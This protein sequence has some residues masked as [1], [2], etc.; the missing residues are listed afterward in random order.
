MCGGHQTLLQS[1]INYN[2]AT[3]AT[4]QEIKI[5]Y[6]AAQEYFFNGIQTS[7]L[8]KNTRWTNRK[9]TMLQG[10]QSA[11]STYLLWGFMVPLPSDEI[12]LP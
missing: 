9:A 12:P 6:Q 10:N 1:I 4:A 2:R 11:A 8:E 7:G 5:L 3:T